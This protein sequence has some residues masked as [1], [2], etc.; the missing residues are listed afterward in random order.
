[1]FRSTAAEFVDL[2]G[3]IDETDA[4]VSLENELG[5][6]PDVLEL[7]FPVLGRIEQPPVLVL[8]DG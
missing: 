5:G 8:S 1:M 4:A 7:H 3:I 6:V 2:L